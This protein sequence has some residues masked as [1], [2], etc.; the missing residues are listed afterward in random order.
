MT[1]AA[2]AR[3]ARRLAGMAH[4]FT[5]GDGADPTAGATLAAEALVY[6]TL[7]T[8]PEQAP[9]A[10]QLE[11]AVA[12]VYRAAWYTAP[13]GTYTT[14]AAARRHCQGDATSNVPNPTGLSFDW[15]GDDT[16]PDEPYQLLVLIDNG[17]E[18]ATDYT[19]TRIEVAAEYDPEADQ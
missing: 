7:A 6:A 1:A 8:I 4:H 2:D 19:V 9:A 11:T 3:E 10:A 17:D 15:L 14:S 16:D 5:Y 18:E 12:Y 13:L